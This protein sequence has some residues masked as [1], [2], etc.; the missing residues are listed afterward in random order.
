MINLQPVEHDVD[1]YIHMI[2]ISSQ[3]NT[4]RTYLL[5]KK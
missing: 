4:F 5:I 1:I 3:K 2:T